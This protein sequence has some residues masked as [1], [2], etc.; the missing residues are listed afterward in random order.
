M[1]RTST[2][3]SSGILFLYSAWVVVSMGVFMAFM[4]TPWFSQIQAVRQGALI[5]RVLGGTLGV[6]GAPASLI[7][8]FGMVIFCVRRDPSSASAKVLWFI[9]FLTTACFGAVVYFFVVYRRQIRRQST[10]T[11]LP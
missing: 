9:L 3:G 2:G 1:Q 10:A 5:L 8:L 7:I 11:S 6:I 4:L